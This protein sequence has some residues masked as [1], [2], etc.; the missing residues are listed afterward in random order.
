MSSIGGKEIVKIFVGDKE[1]NS[2]YVGDNKVYVKEQS[3]DNED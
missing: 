2:V 3:N 1:V